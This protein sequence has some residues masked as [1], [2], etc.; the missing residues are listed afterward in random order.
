MK[1]NEQKHAEEN[2]VASGLVCSF[3]PASMPDN[4]EAE[5]FA[6]EAFRHS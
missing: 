1:W 3:N 6:R 4:P 5:M 2:P